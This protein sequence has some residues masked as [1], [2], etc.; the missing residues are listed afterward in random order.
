MD[1]GWNTGLLV[2]SNKRF[3]LK[4][5]KVRVTF[6]FGAHGGSIRYVAD[7]VALVQ[8]SVRMI[9]EANFLR[10]VHWAGRLVCQSCMDLDVI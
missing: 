3:P 1:L 7:F 2:K 4:P 9:F 6:I 8:L 5:I 10:P